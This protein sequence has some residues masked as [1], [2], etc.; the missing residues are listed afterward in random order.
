MSRYSTWM[1]GF[2]AAKLADTFLKSGISASPWFETKRMFAFWAAVGAAVGAAGAAAA[3]VGSA[4]GVA[5][6]RAGVAA[7]A[8]AARAAPAPTRAAPRQESRRV[9]LGR[10]S[11]V[12]LL[13]MVHD[14]C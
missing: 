14:A 6:G 11:I 13:G 3:L 12:V 2:A 9:S 7:G 8:H 10:F 5:G 4:L 1:L